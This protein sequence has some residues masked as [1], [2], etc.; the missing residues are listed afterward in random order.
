MHLQNGGTKLLVPQVVYVCWGAPVSP[1]TSVSLS[2]SCKASCASSYRSGSRSRPPCDTARL[3]PMCL[4]ALMRL[5]WRLPKAAWSSRTGNASASAG[6]SSI[7]TSLEARVAPSRLLHCR[8]GCGKGKKSCFTDANEG[9]M[10][11]LE[12]GEFRSLRSWS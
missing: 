4:Q 1:T 6:S 12:A 2:G 10:C 3:A 8:R 5:M 11:A 7:E 9:H